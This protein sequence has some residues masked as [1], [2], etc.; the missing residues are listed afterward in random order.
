MYRYIHIPKSKHKYR[1]AVSHIHMDIHTLIHIHT[2]TLSHVYIHDHI[3]NCIHTYIHIYRYTHALLHVHKCMRS[4]SYVHTLIHAYQFTDID[5]YNTLINSDTCTHKCIPG[6]LR[7]AMVK[8]IDCR[9]VVT[10][11]VLQSRYYVHFWANTLG[12][13]MNLPAMG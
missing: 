2:Q 7:G 10:E 8:A 1:Y 11:F 9:F 4:V 12:K 6:C 3:Y 13:W 5:T